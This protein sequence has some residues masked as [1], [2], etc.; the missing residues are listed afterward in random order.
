MLYFKE[1]NI[2]IGNAADLDAIKDACAIGNCTGKYC[3]KNGIQDYLRGCP[4][5]VEE[6]V[7]FMA[8]KCK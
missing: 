5:K 4:P 6:I 1:T 7:K 3:A 2:I 8:N